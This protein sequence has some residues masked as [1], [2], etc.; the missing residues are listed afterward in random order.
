MRKDKSSK[1]VMKPL[2]AVATMVIC[3]GLVGVT[4][5]AT[6]GKLQGFFKDITRWDGAVVG[7]SYEQATDEIQ[8]SVIGESDKLI[9]T[10]EFVNRDIAPYFTFE[11]FGIENY[12]LV[13]ANG[14]VVVEDAKTELVEIVEGKTTF[15]IP[16]SGLGGGNFKLVVSSFVG[17]AKADQPLVMSGNWECEF[18]R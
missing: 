13:D 7:T 8:L 15:E 11:N 17:S 5:L 1:R 10:A 3:V 4:A 18:E 2:A 6:S 12:E 14:N 16:V 9:V